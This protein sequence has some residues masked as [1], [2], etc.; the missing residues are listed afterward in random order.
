MKLAHQLFCVSNSIDVTYPEIFFPL[1]SKTKSTIFVGKIWEMR[2]SFRA[3]KA[4]EVKFSS[5]MI[6][7]KHFRLQ[8]AFYHPCNA[9]DNKQQ[10]KAMIFLNKTAYAFH[11][12]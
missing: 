11:K 12:K 3:Y 8:L 4:L 6:I 7:H 1:H 2:L 10:V 9:A 5:I